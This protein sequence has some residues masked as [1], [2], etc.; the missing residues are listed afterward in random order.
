[1]SQKGIARPQSQVQHYYVF[2]RFTYSHDRYTIFQQQ[3]Q[4]MHAGRSGKICIRNMNV[5]IETEFAK[6][7]FREYLLKIFAKVSLQCS[8]RNRL[9]IL[10]LQTILLKHAVWNKPSGS[11]DFLARFCQVCQT[12]FKRLILK[13]ENMPNPNPSPI[14][15]LR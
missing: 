3:Q 10:Q 8:E 14:I 6:F 7:L 1:M 12:V 2:E 4:N 9:W 15:F 5:G 13:Y 11:G